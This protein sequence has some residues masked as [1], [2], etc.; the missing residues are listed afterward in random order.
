MWG[1]LN[2]NLE[3]TILANQIPAK[4][5]RF[6]ESNFLAIWTNKPERDTNP[7]DRFDRYMIPKPIAKTIN[8]CLI[9]SLR[10]EK[11]EQV[12]PATSTNAMKECIKR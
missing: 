7:K 9:E 5:K 11:L 3:G 6:F 2:L 10:S 12:V 4:Y 1:L 8:E